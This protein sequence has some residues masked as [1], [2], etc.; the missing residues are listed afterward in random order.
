MVREVDAALDAGAFGLSSGLIYAPGMHAG[1]DELAALV[2]AADATR[3]AVRDAHAQRGG[4]LFA[5]LDEAIATIRAARERRRGRGCRSRTSSA[6]PRAVWGRAA[7]GGRAC[8]RR[9]APTAWTWPPTSTRTRPP[10]RPSRRSCRRRCSGSASTSA[11]RPS[12]TTRSAT[13]SAPRW[14]AASRLGERGRGPGL[15][16]H[17]D[18]VRGQPSRTGPAV[19]GRAR[20]DAR[21]GPGRS[22]LRRADRRPPRRLDRH[23]LHGRARTSRRS[24]PCPGSRSAPTP[25]AGGRATRSSTPAG[26][27]RARTGA[28]RASSGTYV[29]ER[30][31][32]A[33]RDGGRQADLACRPA[34]LGLRDRGV[35]REGAFADL[36][37]FDPATVADVATYERAGAAPGRAS[38]TSSSTGALAVRD[39]SETGERAGPPA[40]ARRM[41]AARV[42]RPPTEAPAIAPLPGGP[43]PYTLRHS[44]RARGLRV[45]IHPER[46]VVVTVP[47][48]PVA[49]W[50]DGG[51]ARR[52]RSSPSA[53]RGS[54]AT[55][56]A[57]PTSR[58][59]LAARGGARDGG[60]DP[61]PRRAAS[62]I[63]VV[64]GR[65]PAPA[66]RRR[67][68][69][70][71]R[72][73]R[74]SGRA[75]TGGRTRRSSR[76]GCATRARG[77]DRARDRAATRRRSA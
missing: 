71:R 67:R 15:G 54:A 66:G 37:V 48:T 45:V 18:L 36:V 76:H 59:E 23:R 60:A 57:R 43:L 3:R 69:V 24:W 68:A 53:S 12:A 26:R 27:T 9:R 56:P 72:A 4:G 47:A 34:R 19:A 58:R 52:R 73:G 22:R 25:K 55:S 5:A 32:L 61:V 10:R 8:W 50:A 64:P 29:R 16:G 46:G 35:V 2:T 40:A 14:S 41:T 11:S 28:R 7:R 33:A 44:P 21:R 20:R 63:R 30:G 6:A 65:A 77:R 17:P 70:R 38:S 51:A 31:T 74:P 1:P 42:D 39:G 62:P 49:G 13:A 75:A